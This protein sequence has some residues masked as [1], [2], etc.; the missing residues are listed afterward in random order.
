MNNVYCMSLPLTMS[1]T[2]PHES[3]TENF[4]HCFETR[5]SLVMFLCSSI[6]NNFTR[7]LAFVVGLQEFNKMRL[8]KTKS[9]AIINDCTHHFEPFR[10][11]KWKPSSR[12]LFLLPVS[13]S[14]S[15]TLFMSSWCT[16]DPC[17]GPVCA[18]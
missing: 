14:S 8:R 15:V 9:F 10:F 17:A 13:F 18:S 4:Q 12:F 11:Q 1:I 3:F 7:I 2:R 6:H 16:C 5:F